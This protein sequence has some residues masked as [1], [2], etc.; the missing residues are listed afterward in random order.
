MQLESVKIDGLFDRFNYE[1]ELRRP[2]KITIIH[3]PN[4]F[5]KTVLL[6]LI[7][8]FFSGQFSI[9]F[10]HNFAKVFLRFDNSETIIITKSRGADLFEK[11]VE[12]ARPP[13]IEIG[14]YTPNGRTEQI[15]LNQTETIPDFSRFL[16]FIIPAGPDMWLDENADEILTTQ[17]VLGRYSNA[18]PPAMRK[19]VELPEWLKEITNSTE[20]RLIVSA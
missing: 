8:A 16:P 3:A 18:F 19:S 10:K 12:K 20:C 11:Q 7:N 6:N 4:G 15:T 14:L 5:G 13:T 2:E 9:F 17:E 1:I